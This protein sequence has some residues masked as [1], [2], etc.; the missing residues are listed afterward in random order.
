MYSFVIMNKIQKKNIF[1]PQKILKFGNRKIKPDPD[2]LCDSHTNKICERSFITQT[3]IPHQF[4]RILIIANQTNKYY[5]PNNPNS[6]KKDVHNIVVYINR[7]MSRETR[8]KHTTK[9]YHCKMGA[10]LQRH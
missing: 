3:K 8:L 2:S 7:T 5:I 4:N 6:R 10:A 9:I 1:A